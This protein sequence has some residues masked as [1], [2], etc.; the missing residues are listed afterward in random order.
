MFWIRRFLT[1][2]AIAFVIIAGVQWLKGR[3]S[4]DALF[5]GAFWA[6]LS[7]SLFTATRW[8][9]ARRGEHCALC[10]DTPEMLIESSPPPPPQGRVSP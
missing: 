10:R 3:T 2:F 8:Y 4:A 7:T 6:L 1:V 5:Q 9:R